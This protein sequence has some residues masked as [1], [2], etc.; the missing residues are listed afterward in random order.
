MKVLDVI[1]NGC[2]I[3][4]IGSNVMVLRQIFVNDKKNITFKFHDL[5]F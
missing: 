2:Y 5:E 4:R 1:F 3:K